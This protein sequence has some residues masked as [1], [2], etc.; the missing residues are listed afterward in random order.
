MAAAF[1]SRFH[2]TRPGSLLEASRVFAQFS[3]DNVCRPGNTLLW[4]L[5]QDDKIV[6]IY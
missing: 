6:S 3:V 2:S 1:H 5:L 4:D